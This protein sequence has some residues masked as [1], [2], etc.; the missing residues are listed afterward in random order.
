MSVTRRPTGCWDW[1]I[2]LTKALL[3]SLL[4]GFW[5]HFIPCIWWTCDLSENDGGQVRGAVWA[6]GTILC[7]FILVIRSRCVC[8]IVVYVDVDG[9]E[10]TVNISVGGDDSYRK[11]QQDIKCT[12]QDIG[13]FLNF[14]QYG[15]QNDGVRMR[16][17]N[18][19]ES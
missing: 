1:V 14:K 11:N 18:K 4:F 2:S 12:A 10:K 3:V 15:S 19:N 7:F 13:E 17:C 8:I 6:I 9:I 16:F 5:L